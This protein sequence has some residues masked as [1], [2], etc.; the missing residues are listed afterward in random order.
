MLMPGANTSF[1]LKSL[2]GEEKATLRQAFYDQG[3]LLIRNQHDLNPDV[4]YDI[5]E[6]IDPHPTHFHSGGKRQVTDPRNILAL[7]GCNRI[8]RAPQVTVIGKGRYEGYEGIPELDL[9]HLVRLLDLNP[10]FYSRNPEGPS[11]IPRDTSLR[12][13]NSGRIHKTL[14]VAHGCS[15]VRKPAWLR[16]I[17]SSRR[18]AKNTSPKAAVSR[19]RKHGYC[20][21]LHIM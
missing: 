17:N 21:R 12:Y 19:W 3:V 15:F 7:N 6:L 20:C 14:Q 16:Y 5:A 18:C 10:C 11:I 9:K 8:P 2:S 1:N 13:P 4:L